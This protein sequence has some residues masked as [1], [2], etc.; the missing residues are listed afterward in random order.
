VEKREPQRLVEK[1]EPQRL[2]EKREPQRLVFFAISR[3]VLKDLF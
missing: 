1:R 2:V 3:S